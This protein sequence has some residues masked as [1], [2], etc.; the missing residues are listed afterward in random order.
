MSDERRDVVEEYRSARG[1]YE[2]LTNRLRIL[3]EDLLAGEGKEVVQIEAR[4]KDVESFAEKLSRRGKNYEDPL[5]QI[6][7]L[8]GIR[9]I[10]Y[11]RE[12]VETVGKVVEENFDIDYGNSQNKAELLDPD[13]FGYSSVHFVASLKSDRC[14]LGEWKAYSGIKFEIQIRT[15]LQHAW[16]A[17]N[18]KVDYKSA[19]ELPAPLQRQL[20]RLSALFEMADEEF[21]RIRESA[22]KITSDYVK[23]VQSGKAEIP[24]D[25]ASLIALLGEST[26]MQE[27]RRELLLAGAA[28]KESEVS[29]ERTQ[30][31]RADLVRALRALGAESVTEAERYFI[32]NKDCLLNA[33]DIVTK[34]WTS[35]DFDADAP[36]T[37]P[38][39]L[40]Q[41]I[42]AEQNVD[43]DTFADYYKE[44]LY[45]HFK[46]IRDR[47]FPS[48]KDAS[49]SG[50]KGAS[51]PGGKGA[52]A[53]RRKGAPTRRQPTQRQPN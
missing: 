46:K 2:S 38:D 21:S 43:R 20:Y 50:G 41:L 40:L 27:L 10:T 28:L 5:R 15:A 53:P 39:A 44:D 36:I 7:D 19:N 14:A 4:A 23:D 51:T 11:Y 16:A 13:R 6:T 33:T 35:E 48:G 26:E 1:F 3:V 52:S 49:T 22:E 42:L 31:D 29:P 24:L 47:I 25:T 8:V 34:A 18:H 12:D 45:P 17:V 30:T 32:D 37:F 9:V